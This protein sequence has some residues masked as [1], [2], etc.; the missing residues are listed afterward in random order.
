MEGDLAIRPGSAV[1]SCVTSSNPVLWA[2]CDWLSGQSLEDGNR[3]IVPLQPSTDL[4]ARHTVCR[5]PQGWLERAQ[6][7]E[8]GGRGPVE[9]GRTQQQ[10]QQ[11]G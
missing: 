6:R 8:G 10:T 11:S 4:G 9:K 7:K 5:S 2:S 1:A 3:A